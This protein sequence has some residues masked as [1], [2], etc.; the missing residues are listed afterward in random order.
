MESSSSE[1]IKNLQNQEKQT[2]VFMIKLSDGFRGETDEELAEMKK[3]L[4][5]LEPFDQRQW[6][7][8]LKYRKGLWYYRHC[9]KYRKKQQCL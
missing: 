5:D 3:F 2:K 6:Q 7:A 1:N 8:M 9:I 4:N